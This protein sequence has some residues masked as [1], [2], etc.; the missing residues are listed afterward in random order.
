M[1]PVKK[2]AQQRWGETPIVVFNSHSDWDHV[3][4][5]STFGQNLIVAHEKTYEHMADDG[6]WSYALKAWGKAKNGL[7]EKQL[8]HLTFSKRL[9]FPQDDLQLFYTPGH[10]VD[11]S[12]L[13]DN[14]E[15]V[16]FVGDN[17]E[18][19]LPYLQ[20]HDFS[21]YRETLRLYLDLEPKTIVTSH[22]GIVDLELVK[23]T[24]D[25]VE[26]VEEA[27]N[28]GK[29]LQLDDHDEETQ[30]LHQSNLQ[31]LVISRVEERAKEKWGETF[32]TER[33]IEFIEENESDVIESLEAMLLAALV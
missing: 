23:I 28:K 3:W 31:S 16:L 29:L 14:R 10:T 25:Y 11:S 22:S 12:S 2:L 1:E 32:S 8:P 18:L 24:L 6:R 33:F 13:W 17:L 15:G 5:N 20:S 9:S 4:G 7:I 27:F 21:S 19:P 30:A 26:K